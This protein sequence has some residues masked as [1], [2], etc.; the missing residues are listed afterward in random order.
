MWRLPLR[1]LVTA[2]TGSREIVTGDS[3]KEQ[4]LCI[5][6]NQLERGER[7]DII[8]CYKN[9]FY[10]AVHC[11]PIKANATH[12]GGLHMSRDLILSESLHKTTI[13]PH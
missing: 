4:V 2:A 3:Y 9:Y 7:T 13:K 10:F 8:C 1:G 12:K 5:V 11:A 6:E